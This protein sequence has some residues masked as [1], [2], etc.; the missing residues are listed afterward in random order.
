MKL[1]FAAPASVRPSLPTALATQA[2]RLHFFRKLVLAAPAKGLPSLLTALLSQVSCA[3]ATAKFR[4]STRAASRIRFMSL[5]FV[6]SPQTRYCAPAAHERRAAT[7]IVCAPLQPN[8][9][10]SAFELFV[11]LA[12][13]AAALLDPSQTAVGVARLIGIVLIQARVQPP[14][15]S[16]LARVFRRDRSRKHRTSGCLRG[17]CGRG[18]GRRGWGRGGR[19]GAALGFAEIAPVLSAESSRGPGRLVLRAAFL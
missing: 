10:S 17:C 13:I 11:T 8:Q 6:G 2:S 7:G 3:E 19:I 12:V 14:L 16:G 9:I 1:R 15:A 18:G 5:S 4:D